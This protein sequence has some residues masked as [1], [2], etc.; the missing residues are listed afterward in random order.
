MARGKSA[1]QSSRS[2]LDLDD[3]TLRILDTPNRNGSNGPE[4]VAGAGEK[5]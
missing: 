1:G 4:P 2:P 3:M 5:E